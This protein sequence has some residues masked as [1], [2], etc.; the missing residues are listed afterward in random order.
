VAKVLIE[1]D[2]ETEF[3]EDEDYTHVGRVQSARI[4]DSELTPEQ[5]SSFA[6]SAAQRDSWHI[7]ESEII[8]GAFDDE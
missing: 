3:Y 8:L 5:L 4:V 6:E 7:S 1:L 2:I